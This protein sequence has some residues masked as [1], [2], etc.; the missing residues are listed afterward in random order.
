MT[1]PKYKIGDSVVAKR[2]FYYGLMEILGAYW[3]DE[4]EEWRYTVKERNGFVGHC[5][6]ESEIIFPK[7]NH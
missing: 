3:N 2:W 4:R 5:R 1:K 6:G 7:Q